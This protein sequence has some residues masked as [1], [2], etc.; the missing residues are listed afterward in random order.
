MLFEV[1][2]LEWLFFWKRVGERL[3]HSNSEARRWIKENLI[4]AKP[5]VIN[6][7]GD[8]VFHGF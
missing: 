8:V 2:Q 4:L 3:F 1:Q 6:T 7:S 5:I